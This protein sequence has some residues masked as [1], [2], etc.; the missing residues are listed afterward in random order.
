MAQKISNLDNTTLSI[1]RI[2]IQMRNKLP[3]KTLSQE[4]NMK[5]TIQ[6]QQKEQTEVDGPT[7]YQKC[8][9]FLELNCNNY[10]QFSTI[11]INLI[12]YMIIRRFKKENQLY[13]VL[14][15]FDFGVKMRC[16]QEMISLSIKHLPRM[17]YFERN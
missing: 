4:K 12:I 11:D 13:Y 17:H 16:V 9:V 3:R 7:K 2:F 5:E 6:A 15:I 14:K 10:L 8:V 1:L